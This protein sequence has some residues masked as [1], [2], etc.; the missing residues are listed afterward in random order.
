M[1][2]STSCPFAKSTRNM[3]FGSGVFT[4]PSTSIPSFLLI[5]SLLSRAAAA[6]RGADRERNSFAL[7]QRQHFR[8]AVR[9]SDR[10]LK[11]RRKTAVQRAHRP[12]VIMLLRA[13]VSNIHH[14]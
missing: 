3:A 7:S 14:G 2:A 9:N 6:S 11:V 13:P 1:W 4:T 5:L 8:L 10:V 12:A